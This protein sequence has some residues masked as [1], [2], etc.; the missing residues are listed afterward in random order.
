MIVPVFSKGRALKVPKAAVAP[1]LGVRTVL[2]NSPWDFVSLWLRREQRSEAYF[3]WNQ[4]KEF[5]EASASLATRSSPL[6]HYYSFMNAAKALLSSKGIAFEAMHGVRAHNMRTKASAIDLSNEGIQILSQGILPAVSKYFDEK[7]ISNRHSLDELLFNIPCVH[8]TFCLTYEGQEDLFLP[9]TDCEYCFDD[10]TGE[11]HFA[12][13]LSVDFAAQRFK[14]RL[15]QSLVVDLQKGDD[16]SIR[17]TASVKLS[18]AELLPE[19]TDTFLAFHRELRKDLNYINGPQ[20]LWYAKARVDG[21]KRLDRS[22]LTISLGA[23]HRLSELCRYKPL[24]LDSFLAGDK[25][26]LLNEFVKM[27]P[28]QFIDEI[29]AE[30]TG[31]QFMTPNVRAAT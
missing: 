17:S 11:A 23:M 3:F 16:R 24:E 31:Y 19:E 1:R 26:W 20:T 4:A 27:T 8:R 21:F 6:L 22:P 2:T 29:S 13:K 12:A 5:A 7:E 9:L 10:S 28:S 30:I 15:P 18:S 25:N 14:D